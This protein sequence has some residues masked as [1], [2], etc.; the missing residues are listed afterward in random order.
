MISGNIPFTDSQAQL[1]A[2]GITFK[3]ING[4]DATSLLGADAVYVPLP[5]GVLTTHPLTPT[6]ITEL[7]SFMSGGG[8]VIVQMEHPGWSAVDDDVIKKFGFNTSQT[9]NTFASSID[10]NATIP[11]CNIC[12]LNNLKFKQ[13]IRLLMVLMVK[14][15]F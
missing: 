15:R 9:P 13:I 14:L 2:D 12:G 1:E 6:Q 5:A 4:T 3:E 10:E 7:E 8:S 11:N